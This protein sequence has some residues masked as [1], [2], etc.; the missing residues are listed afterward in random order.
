M[1]T[2]HEH[3]SWTLL[4]K[5]YKIDLRNLGRYKISSLCLKLINKVSNKY[6]YLLIRI[7]NLFDNILLYLFF[8]EENIIT[9]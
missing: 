2:V 3:C 4:K 1:D 9:N 8:L 5:R 6:S 7:Y